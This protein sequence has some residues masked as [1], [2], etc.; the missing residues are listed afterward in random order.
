[1]RELIE[2]DV[3]RALEIA[4]TAAGGG[5][6]TA[7]GI[8]TIDAIAAPIPADDVACVEWRFGDS[9]LI[10]VAHRPEEPSLLDDALDTACDSYPL[11]DID[12][13][14][15]P[16][17]LR[18][19]DVVSRVRFLEERVLLRRDEAARPRTRAEVVAAR[20]SRPCALL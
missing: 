11:R 15:S 13:A 20:A 17:P 12:H 10:R 3:H 19:S 5:N 2:R 18:I 8:E 7:F 6:G 16:E 14:G 1:M 9:D 4:A